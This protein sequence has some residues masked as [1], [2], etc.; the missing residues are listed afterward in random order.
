MH[1]WALAQYTVPVVTM[2]TSRDCGDRHDGFPYGVLTRLL[3]NILPLFPF[4]IK[5]IIL[6]STP[7]SA[8]SDSPPSSASLIITF[9]RSA[10]LHSFFLSRQRTRS[11]SL[12]THLSCFS[13]LTQGASSSGAPGAA[14]LEEGVNSFCSWLA[15]ALPALQHPPSLHPSYY[16]YTSPTMPLIL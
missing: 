9:F 16:S 12:P 3:Q 7:P 5:I 2:I 11:S 13:S 4:G 6:R 1:R 15:S 10:S 14:T 8:T